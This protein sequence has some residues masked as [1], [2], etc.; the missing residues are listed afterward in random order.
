MKLKPDGVGG[1]Q[2]SGIGGDPRTMELNL[3]AAVEN[4]P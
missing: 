3:H 1:G 4:E 2:Q